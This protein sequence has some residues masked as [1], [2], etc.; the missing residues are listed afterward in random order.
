MSDD[1]VVYEGTFK[2]ELLALVGRY[3]NGNL[4]DPD[5]VLREYVI[6]CIS[7]YDS[8]VTEERSEDRQKW[9]SRISKNMQSRLK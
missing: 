8:A 6:R 9:W 7:A 1:M 5:A 2:T 3:N 4:T